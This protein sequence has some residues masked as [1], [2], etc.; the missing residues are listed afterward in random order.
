[1]VRISFLTMHEEQATALAKELARHELVLFMTIE[2]HVDLA[3]KDGDLTR[4]PMTHL[5][6]MTKSLLYRRIE[7]EAS[8]LLGSGLVRMWAE[9][10]TSLDP[11]S[12]REL[13]SGTAKV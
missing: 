3:F 2:D 11:D 4:T 9:A 13:L 1:M 5:S 8:A 7:L 10:V 6:G 12:T